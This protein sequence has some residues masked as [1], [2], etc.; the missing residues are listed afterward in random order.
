M[1]AAP[2][3]LSRRKART[4]W[5]GPLAMWAS[6]TLVSSL[7]PTGADAMVGHVGEV[8]HTVSADDGSVFV[9][10]ELWA[11]RTTGATVPIGAPVRVVQ[12]HDL[13][14]VVEPEPQESS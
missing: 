6:G 10:G 11:A 13:T 7:A 4:A 9:N 1:G 8:R 5:A 14:L 2:R 3:P 12:M